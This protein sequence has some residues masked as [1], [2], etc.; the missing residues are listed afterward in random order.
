MEYH[1]EFLK[2]DKENKNGIIVVSNPPALYYLEF[3][4]TKITIGDKTSNSIV[5]NNFR[6]F[7]FDGNKEEIKSTYQKKEVPNVI[8]IEAPFI[9]ED[10]KKDNTEVKKYLIEL[11][12]NNFSF[13]S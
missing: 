3:S 12:T 10:F 9:L 2:E 4:I 6:S 8:Y 5:F 1:F 11:L 7:T 13:Y